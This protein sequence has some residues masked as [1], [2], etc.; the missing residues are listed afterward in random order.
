M[1]HEPKAPSRTPA[2]PAPPPGNDTVNTRIEEAVASGIELTGVDIAAIHEHFA[3]ADD[4]NRRAGRITQASSDPLR[5]GNAFPLGVGYTRMTRTAEKRLDASV[6]R[7]GE[8]VELARRAQAHLRQAEDMLA[9]K[10]TEAHHRKVTAARDALRSFIVDRLLTWKKGDVFRQFT[11]KRVNRDRE[12]YP[13]S[14]SFSGPD[15]IAG[16]NDKIDVVREYFGGNREAFRALVDQARA[17]RA[18]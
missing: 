12:G 17:A 2:T 9:G 3:Q 6:R 11:I 5:K 4:L 15:I 13:A 18:V 10:D 1:N 14:Y 16:H 8:A 7:A